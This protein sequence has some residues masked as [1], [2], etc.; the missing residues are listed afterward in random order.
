MLNEGKTI[1]LKYNENSFLISF[2]SVSYQYQQDIQYSYQLK[3][4]EQNWSA[5]TKELGIR[6][7]NIPPGDYTFHVK[8]MSKNGGRQLDEQ[9]IRIHIAQ[10]YWNTTLAW[11]IY[12]ILLAGITYFVWRFFANKMEKKHFSE[13]IQFFINTAH[14]IRTLVTLIMAPLGDL[15]KEEGLSKEGKRYLQIAR[16]NTEKLYNLITQL[17]DF[18]KIDTT[19]LTLQVAEYDLKSYLQEKVLSFQT[20]CESKQIRMQLLLPDSPVSLW[21]DKDKADKIFDNLFSNAVKYT[22]A[23]GE[24]TIKVEQNDKKITIAVKDN[25]IGIPRKAQ[26]YIFSNFY[27][28]ENA[29]NSKETGSGIGLLLTRR[30][31]KLHKGHISFSSNE[32]EGSTFLLTFRKGNRH[33]ARYIVPARIDTSILPV[34]E[35]VIKVIEPSDLLSDV[36]DLSDTDLSDTDTNN[37]PQTDKSKE[38]IMIVEDNDELR[39]YL[40]KTFAPIYSV[41]DKPDGESALEYLKDKSVELIISDVMMPGIQGDELC[42]RI[43]SDFATSHIPVILLTAKTEKDAILEGLESG[44]DEDN[45]KIDA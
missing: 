34:A 45:D 15:S 12:I 5:P 42:R 17:L 44:A 27:R 16:K 7:T 29:V 35:P 39:F 1:R 11:L 20:L 4:F 36:P 26:R 10:P 2:I 31:M 33:L 13:K 38:R 18:Q 9:T 8:S 24:I 37:A 40:K 43:K 41:I 21:M 19:H 30:L 22:P 3:G 25:G 6:Y 28:A 14:D 23:G 32:G